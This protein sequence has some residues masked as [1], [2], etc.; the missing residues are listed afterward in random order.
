MAG[1]MVKFKDGTAPRQS[2]NTQ[3]P[4]GAPK[5]IAPSREFDTMYHQNGG[6]TAQGD[7]S[8]L[9]RSHGQLPTSSLSDET[10]ATPCDQDGGAQLQPEIF[11]AL[12]GACR[13]K[14]ILTESILPPGKH[15][16]AFGIR[17]IK[18]LSIKV[19][20]K[21]NA[22]PCEAPCDQPINWSDR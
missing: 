22:R 8:S 12:G 4:T 16:S 10:M 17:S 21:H 14:T 20:N 11:P 19:R 3:L 13:K 7:T 5:T 18:G 9:L 15:V 6:W 1:L 2:K